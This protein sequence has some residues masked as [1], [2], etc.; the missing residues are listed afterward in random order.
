[1]KT[2]PKTEKSM[3]HYKKTF[4][5]L[6]CFFFLLGG[7]AQGK[8]ARLAWKIYLGGECAGSPAIDGQ[9]IIVASKGGTLAKFT[10]SG[11]IVWQKN[12]AAAFF[13][14]PAITAGGDIYAAGLDGNLYCFSAGGTLKWQVNLGDELRA[15]PLLTATELFVASVSGKIFKI[16]QKTGMIAQQIDLKIPV[17]S[18]PVWDARRQNLL[19]PVKDYYLF[20][21]SQ[22]LQVNWKYKTAGVNFS[23]PAVTPQNEI[24]F[25]SMDHHCY[26]IA[27]DGN[28]IWKYKT[29][30][31]LMSSPVIDDRG[32]V[33]FGSH[34]LHFYVV[35][36]QGQPLWKFKGLAPF[37]STAV[38]DA[39][40]RVYCGD[41]SGTVYALKADGTLA[42]K[43]K[44]EDFITSGLT[45]VPGVN[46]LLA[47]SIDGTLLAFKIEQ[48]MAQKAWW[49]KY[50]GNL[51]NSGY[52]E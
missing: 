19:L 21:V 41:S 2:R 7:F 50:L 5:V 42:W 9:T 46:I 27:G 3:K 51:Q 18:S 29:R 20:S 36:A 1:M 6:G 43:F 24:Y 47:G 11:K 35:D 38:I 23:V 14:A 16:A 15:T 25:T 45:I 32:R 34:D 12:L 52:A 49:A 44:S 48:P 33:Y 13:A 10:N 4:L 26:K 37:N 22:K 40:G 17:F 28:L 39:A 8:Q 30:G 31:W